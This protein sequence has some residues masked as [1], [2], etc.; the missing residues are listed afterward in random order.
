MNIVNKLNSKFRENKMLYILVLIF[1][2]VGI[3]LG[4]YTIKYMNVSDTTELS[5]YFTGFINSLG[6][7]PV[8]SKVL[9][10]EVLKKNIVVIILI[11]V[12]SFTIVGS[13]II[14]LVDL[15]KGF[16]LGYTFSFLITT[17][18]GKGIWIALAS[19]IPQNLFYI[20]FLIG[21][22]I[23]SID[24]SS[25]KLKDKFS[26]KGAKNNIFSNELLIKLAFLFCLFVLGVIVETFVCPSLIKFIATKFY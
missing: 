2:C 3:V 5:S 12:S 10:M 9:L 17:F 11:L 4:T 19:I 13:P 14:L 8:D 16:T 1:F 22:S 26:N 18:S 24:M 20:P 6:V 15:V 7:Q 21:I 23:M 25:M